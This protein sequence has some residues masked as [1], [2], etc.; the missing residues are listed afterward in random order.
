MSAN[1]NFTS[2]NDLVSDFVEGS[3]PLP[4]RTAAPATVSEPALKAL[5]ALVYDF[6]IVTIAPDAA[7]QAHLDALAALGQ[8]TDDISIEA[9][10]RDPAT[11]AAM[12]QASLGVR[13]LFKAAGFGPV[14]SGVALPAGRFP[15]EDAEARHAVVMRLT[16]TL[17]ESDATKFNWGQL[18]IAAFF[19]AQAEATSVR[20]NTTPVPPKP[21]PVNKQK[22]ALIGLVVGVALLLV[23]GLSAL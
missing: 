11:A 3:K 18:D 4:Q 17:S 15:A 5:P 10:W 19:K 13:D 14:A 9:R 7:Q 16:N 6:D 21:A 1:F 23:A 2:D 8:D 20:T 22:L 12:A